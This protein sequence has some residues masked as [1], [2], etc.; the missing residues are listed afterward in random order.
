M[1]LIAIEVELHLSPY[2]L[3]RGSTAA[4]IWPATPS[5]RP[6]STT[7]PC[8]RSSHL[9]RAAAADAAELS[10]CDCLSASCA[11]S[12]CCAAWSSARTLA[13]AACRTQSRQPMLLGSLPCNLDDTAAWSLTGSPRCQQTCKAGNRVRLLLAAAGN[14]LVLANKRLPSN[15][16]KP[17]PAAEC[18]AIRCS[19][20]A[21]CLVCLVCSATLTASKVQVLAA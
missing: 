9:P 1:V 19:R 14:H 8:R 7:A 18:D 21:V 11:C 2:L 4:L 6:A 5:Q 16:F 12:C 20:H 10:S 13:V 3:L 15:M 17:Q